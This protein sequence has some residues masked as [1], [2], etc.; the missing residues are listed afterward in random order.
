VRWKLRPLAPAVG[1]LLIGA[2]PA[3]A[4]HVLGQYEGTLATGGKV[5][6]LVH[7]S[8]PPTPSVASFAASPWPMGKTEAGQDCRPA[9][10]PENPLYN[11]IPI[12][13]HAFS[14]TAPPTLISGSFAAPLGA[15][16]TLRITTESWFPPPGE[17][18]LGSTCDTGALSWTASCTTAVPSPH[19]CSPVPDGGGLPTL[20]PTSAAPTFGNSG[21]RA[22][23]SR[24][25]RVTLPLTIGCPPPGAECLVSVA[26]TARLRARASARRRRVKVGRLAYAVK[27]GASAQA[28]FKLTPKG[29][30]LLRRVRRVRA[31]VEI[32][33]TRATAI[34]KKTVTVRLKAPKRTQRPRR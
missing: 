22:N 14:D 19:L 25:G 24:G 9:G 13:D 6:F 15:T 16:G 11:E 33:V 31:K 10:P 1:L 2:A 21:S 26:A 4:T 32:T 23:V 29:R 27:V 34:T 17:S 3:G 20:P 5:S 12:V 8:V 18:R 7:V 28:R 30:R